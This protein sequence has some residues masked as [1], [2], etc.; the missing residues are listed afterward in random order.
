MPSNFLLSLLFILLFII[1]H[2]NPH[3]EHEEPGGAPSSQG[4]SPITSIQAASTLTTG[5]TTTHLSASGGASEKSGTVSVSVSVGNIPA[6]VPSAPAQEP[7]LHIALG[8]LLVVHIEHLLIIYFVGQR[9]ILIFGPPLCGKSTQA[10]MLALHFKLPIIKLDEILEKS[11][12][13]LLANMAD[14]HLVEAFTSKYLILLF[15]LYHSIFLFVWYRL[16]EPDCTKGV[17]VDGLNGKH[18]TEDKY[19]AAWVKAIEN[20]KGKLSDVI[21]CHINL[22]LSTART[23]QSASYSMLK[24]IFD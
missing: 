16:K 8:S 23:R 20:V 3:V 12:F 18:A 15:N 11:R 13:P 6:L 4:P 9:H 21:V 5:P 22:S 10:Q 19:A 17:I 24:F 2:R 14:A 1:A 7:S